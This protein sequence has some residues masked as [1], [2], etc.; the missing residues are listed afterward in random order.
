[1]EINPRALNFDRL[2]LQIGSCWKFQ[3]ELFYNI[4]RFNKTV[5]IS[6]FRGE[7]LLSVTTFGCYQNKL[8]KLLSAIKEGVIKRKNLK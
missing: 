3:W 4:I 6:I 1:M 8:S 2:Q 5:I 7:I